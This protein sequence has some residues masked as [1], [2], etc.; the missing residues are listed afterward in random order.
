MGGVT[1][2]DLGGVIPG[3]LGDTGLGGG[4]KFS[5]GIFH[6]N[7]DIISGISA[8]ISLGL[9]NPCK[10][11]A[12]KSPIALNIMIT[13]SLT[14]SYAYRMAYKVLQIHPMRC[15]LSIVINPSVGYI[16]SEGYC[17]LKIR[18]YRIGDLCL[19]VV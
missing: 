13:N 18:Y 6:I 16:L 12:K 9:D 19:R 17:S 5:T 4:G 11:P 3:V 8:F 2:G 10:K 1:I 14:L 7:G 15:V